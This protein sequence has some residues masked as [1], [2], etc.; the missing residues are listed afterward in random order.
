M[1]QAK[2]SLLMLSIFI[3]GLLVFG[4]GGCAGSL[5]HKIFTLPGGH[6]APSPGTGRACCLVVS[7][8]WVLPACPR[9]MGWPL[10]SITK[11]FNRILQDFP[12]TSFLQWQH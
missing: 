10:A 6:Q 8:I 4:F 1:A 3:K 11:K 2:K 5:P 9:T 7:T 12:N